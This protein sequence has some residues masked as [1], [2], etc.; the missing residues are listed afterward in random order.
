MAS[1]QKVHGL[2]VTDCTGVV[3]GN[4]DLECAEQGWT[5]TPETADGHAAPLPIYPQK[6][7]LPDPRVSALIDTAGIVAF[8]GVCFALGGW[9]L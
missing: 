4:A 7:D 5:N 2:E 1:E 6:S 8:A 3:K 9:L